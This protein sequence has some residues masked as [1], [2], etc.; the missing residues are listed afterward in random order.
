MYDVL[1][2]MM[3]MSLH[4]HLQVFAIQLAAHVTHQYPLPDAMGVARNVF[5][6][7]NHL[8]VEIPLAKQEEVFKP[9][10]PAIVI[11]CEAFPP[12]CV[13]ATEFLLNLSKVCYV[14]GSNLKSGINISSLAKIQQ[15]KT[16]DATGQPVQS[17]KPII[18]DT[19]Q[20]PS[21]PSQDPVFGMEDKLKF[22]K[23]ISLTEGAKWTFQQVV[24][25]VVLKVSGK[26]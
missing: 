15:P 25:K 21:P 14:S 3:Y 8:V 24:K 16:L 10:L 12:L 13:D 20:E 5:K 23:G 6:K 26:T 18:Q 7:L 1:T 11:F 22:L 4:V 2:C 9:V 19:D 17:P